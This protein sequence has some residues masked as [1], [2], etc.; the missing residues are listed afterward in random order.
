MSLRPRKDHQWHP[1]KSCQLCRLVASKLQRR[2]VVGLYQMPWQSA[3]EI[4]LRGKRNV[5]QI[6]VFL[7]SIKTGLVEDESAIVSSCF[8][9]ESGHRTLQ[10]LVAEGWLCGEATAAEGNGGRR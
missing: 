8:G 1:M 7:G 2:L 10:G 9:W 6:R 4:A 3:C 5:N